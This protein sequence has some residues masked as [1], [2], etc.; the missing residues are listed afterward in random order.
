MKTLRPLIFSL[1]LF[2]LI[3]MGVN[4][5]EAAKKVHLK[6]VKGGVTT[7]DT[8][9]SASDLEDEDLHKKISELAGVDL[10]MIHGEDMSIH[11]G[12]K[13]HSGHK[14]AHS[15]S[16]VTVDD[17]EGSEGKVKKKIIVKK[18]GEGEETEDVTYIYSTDEDMKKGERVYIIKGD[19][20]T[21]VTKEGNVM[22]VTSGG[23]KNVWVTKEG[24]EKETTTVIVKHVGDGEEGESEKV[25]IIEDGKEI[26]EKGEHYLI[27]ELDEDHKGHVKVIKIKKGEGDSEEVTITVITD[28]ELHMDHKHK[29]DVN[30]V[31]SEGKSGTVIVKKDIEVVK[32]I[33]EGGEVIEITVVINEGEKKEK[34]E[35]SSKTKQKKEKDRNKK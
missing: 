27:E 1:S 14:E 16:Y 30:V 32:T 6:V 4:G 17:D 19:S 22:I 15:Y 12:H 20:G 28:D 31:V 8:V 35:K 26:H 21:R 25:I 29:G 5:Q 3:I 23:E 33:D 13:E 18:S 7:I 2:G 34:K 24:E 9:F 11:A 10:E